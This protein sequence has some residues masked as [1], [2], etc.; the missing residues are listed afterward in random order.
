M[1][2]REFKR[3]TT[4]I[5]QITQE[6]EITEEEE[7]NIIEV[8]IEAVIITEE[9]EVDTTPTTKEVAE[10]VMKREIEEILDTKKM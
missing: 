4:N 7:D 8:D 9:I 10:V 5:D 3:L 2:N 6:T 1:I